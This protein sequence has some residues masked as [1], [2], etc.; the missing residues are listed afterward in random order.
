MYI[1]DGFFHFFLNRLD[2]LRKCFPTAVTSKEDC[3]SLIKK[4]SPVS[5][6]IELIRLGPAGDGGYLLPNDLS[7]IEACFSPGVSN[8]SGFEKDCADMGMKVFL[9][10]GT[11]EAPVLQHTNFMFLKKNIGVTASNTIER[12]E[13]WVL[14][15]PISAT[16]D[17]L[18]QM[19]IEGSEYG[20]FLDT[21]ESLLKRFRIMVV[22]FHSLNMLFCDS[23]FQLAVA[24]FEK[25]L[26]HHTCVHLH[27]NNCCGIVK[28]HGIEIPITM[29]FTFLRNDRFRNRSPARIPS[30]LDTDNVPNNNSLKLSPIWVSG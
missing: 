29:E 16:T 13:D 14:S 30:P 4:I 21:P 15:S 28:M 11:I 18:L 12:I 1:M 17:L 10:D 26:Q 2:A 19:D 27:P 9:A 23:F 6:G 22:E 5:P 25:I 20:V 3:V 7:D 8:I 24:M